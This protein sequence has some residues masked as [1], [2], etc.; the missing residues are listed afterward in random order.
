[1]SVV[2]TQTPDEIV[3]TDEVDVND[4][5]YY[6]SQWELI[7]WRFRRHQLAMISFVLL[8]LLYFVAIFADF[9]SP[10]TTAIRFN[11]YQQAPPTGIHIFSDD[12]LHSP[13]IYGLERTLDQ[14]TFKYEFAEDTSERYPIRFFIKGEP[15]KLL[16]LWQT[17]L[18]FF[19]TGEG[20]PPV[21]LFGT[22]RLGRDI[23]R[24][25]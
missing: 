21:I 5:Y 16:G 13:F 3:V 11:D 20:N 8:L 4:R 22:D 24:A 14:A 12:G 18:H 23:S 17:D 19:G 10:Y 9:F 6:A 15:Y 7:W 1:M 2:T 25:P